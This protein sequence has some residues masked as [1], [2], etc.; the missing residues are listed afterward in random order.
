LPCVAPPSVTG[1]S[2]GGRAGTGG[3]AGGGAG[4][5]VTVEAGG[6][7]EA[8]DGAEEDG[9]HEGSAFAS[10]CSLAKL[11]DSEQS[12]TSVPEER[13]SSRNAFSNTNSPTSMPT[14][15]GG[16]R[17]GFFA[18]GGSQQGQEP[19]RLVVQGHRGAH[20]AQQ[21]GA[22]GPDKVL[23]QRRNSGR[24]GRESTSG[25]FETAPE[26]LHQGRTP[27]FK[28]TRKSS[29]SEAD[30]SDSTGGLR[31]GSGNP[32]PKLAPVG[33]MS[34][35]RYLPQPVDAQAD[36]AG[37]PARP[38]LFSFRSEGRDRPILAPVHEDQG[39]APLPTAAAQKAVSSFQKGQLP[40]ELSVSQP[41]G[42]QGQRG[43]GRESVRPGTPTGDSRVSTDEQIT[44]LHLARS[45]TPADD[46][47]SCG[48]Q[49]MN[50]RGGSLSPGTDVRDA[51]SDNLPRP[52]AASPLSTRF[53]G[54]F[55]IS[56]RW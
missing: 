8:G 45:L 50:A 12:S 17:R 33:D 21:D 26:F 3:C 28:P 19:S 40:A 7:V 1:S 48:M 24:R 37:A 4:L 39:S 22:G 6:G 14:P 55:R 44:G 41:R 29:A 5:G 56:N 27:S 23:A 42:V 30:A 51:T 13:P 15:R 38:P 53:A 11:Q 34:A 25:D 2:V 32:T 54:V 52:D 31:C 16:K 35:M 20:V 47:T 18:S 49:G 46:D 36:Q 10:E 9:R 43:L